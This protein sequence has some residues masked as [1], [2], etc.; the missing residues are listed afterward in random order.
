MSARRVLVTGAAGGIGGGVA[1]AFA[2]LG[3]RVAAADLDPDGVVRRPG[4]VPMAF[5]AAD[6]GSCDALVREAAAALGGIDVLVVA[7]GVLDE[8]PVEQLTIDA[9]R[10]MLD[11]G[12]TSA[13]VLTRAV[14]PHMVG[15][16]RIVLISSQVARKGAVGLAH[17][18]AAKAGLLGFM[19]SVAREVVDRGILV[20]A[21]APGPIDTAM[22]RAAHRGG[23]P[24]LDA[25][26]RRRAGRIDEIV[27]SVLLLASSPGGD[28]YVGQTLGPNGGDVML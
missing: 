13:F 17:Y 5:D 16:G 12:L 25:V 10:R 7:H 24:D 26:P 11:I 28:Y 22:L 27:P 3:D 6:A 19:R 18:A 2:D 1:A 9:W 14:I 15:G 23:A 21:V 20:N 4:V 8:A